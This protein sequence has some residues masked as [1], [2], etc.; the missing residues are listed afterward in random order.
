MWQCTPL[1][2]ALKTQKQGDLCE[3]HKTLFQNLF[4][5]VKIEHNI[6]KLMGV[7]E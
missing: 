1:I 7:A 2:P 3:L 6:L 5:L 4:E